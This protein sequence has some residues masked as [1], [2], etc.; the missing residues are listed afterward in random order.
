ML[1][2]EKALKVG[3]MVKKRLEIKRRHHHVWAWY[4][5]RWSHDGKNVHYT[6]AKRKITLDSVRGVAVENF[7]YRINKLTEV[8]IEIFNASVARMD[9]ELQPLH[10]EYIRKVFKIQQIHTALSQ[11]GVEGADDDV[12]RVFQATYSNLLENIHAS[13]ERAATP[14]LQ[15]LSQGDMNV[16][17]DKAV[18]IEFVSY[19]SHQ[20]FRTKSVRDSVLGTIEAQS[21]LQPEKEKYQVIVDSMARHWWLYSYVFGVNMS[22]SIF[23]DRH[24]MRQSLLVN[25]TGTPF[26]TGD[27]P[28]INIHA[29]VPE[30]KSITPPPSVDLYYPISP[31]IAY[32]I[33]ESDKFGFGKVEV[34]AET[35]HDLNMKIARS[36]QVHV[37]GN[38]ECALA[39]YVAHINARNI[40]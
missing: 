22:R 25:H 2:T 23:L 34:D 10:H 13:H 19:L 36:A 4:L 14:T 40:L 30:K 29:S 5:T 8:D 26:I 37:F 33:A 16:L 7:F 27:Q 35:A 20:F 17:T 6:T 18:F 32:V 28:V 15:A 3:E 39:P 11:A 1:R 21:A 31:K 38:S 24:S 12:S 9:L